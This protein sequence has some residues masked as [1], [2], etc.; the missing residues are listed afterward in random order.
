MTDK[1]KAIVMAYTGVAMLTGDKLSTFYEYISEICER[2]IYTHELADN[3]VV[4]EIKTKSYEDFVGICKEEAFPQWIPCSERLPSNEHNLE[5][6]LTTVRYY[7]ATDVFISVYEN[8]KFG[9]WDGE[10][11]IPNENVIAWMEL[12][13]PYKGE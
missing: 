7:G 2:S 4:Q 11:L 8:G 3:D 5:G 1:E 9:H 13:K 6:F 10:K 12:P